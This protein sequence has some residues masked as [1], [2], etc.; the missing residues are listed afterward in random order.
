MARCEQ[1]GCDEAEYTQQDVEGTLRSFETRARW[2]VEPAEPPID[3][4]PATGA[5]DVEHA[6]WELARWV[7][8]PPAQTGTVVQ[9]NV[10]GGGVP[11]SPVERAE[12]GLR[13]L[14]GDRQAA[15]KHHGRPWQALSLWS[16]EVIE[17]LQAEGHPIER[18]SAGENVT[19]AGIDWSVMRPGVR[20]SVGEVE[21]VVSAYAIPC[22][23]NAQWFADRDYNRI[24][25]DR[26]PG[27]SRVYATVLRPGLVSTG[28]GLTLPSS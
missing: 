7:E 10:S 6:L 19:V 18:G 17:S 1:C 24:L 23:K 14:V 2:I 4:P 25:H 11:K 9:L 13:G 20:F 27:T 26:H 21:A 28:N 8:P 16:A 12:V 5:H 3:L 15:R 22:A